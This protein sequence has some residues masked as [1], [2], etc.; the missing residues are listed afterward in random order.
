MAPFRD[1]HHSASAVSLIGGGANPKP[2][3][4]SLAHHGVLFLDEMAEFPKRTLDMFRQPIENGS[5]TI[6]RTAST[7]TY[8]ADF[9][10]IAAMN[11]C[12]CGYL[13]SKH[14]YCTCTPK[15]VTAYNNR[16]SGP[17]QDRID[18][19]L[20]LD[21]VSLT[22]DSIAENESSTA[23]RKS[24][25]YA[26]GSQYKRYG[27]ELYNANV[28]SEKIL[29]SSSLNQEQE[30]MMRKWSSEYHWSTRVQVKIRRL[31]RTISDLSG[32]EHITNEA[33]WEAVTIRRTQ[34]TSS[35]KGMVK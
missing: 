25:L 26:R 16:I 19:I 17:I 33:I 24:V 27:G 7:V 29:A 31:A 20:K 18:I 32:D 5:V 14:R 21:K 10:L 1:P 6:S 8:P 9:I 3:E 23:I 13:G 35:Q 12:P 15:Q 4:V 34:D 11:P 22:E 2:G 30:T 28:S